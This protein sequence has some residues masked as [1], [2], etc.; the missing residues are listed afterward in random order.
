MHLYRDREAQAAVNNLL[1]V[2]RERDG[3]QYWTACHSERKLYLSIPN[4]HGT[5][6]LCLTFLHRHL[7]LNHIRFPSAS[8]HRE[9]NMNMGSFLPTKYHLF[10]VNCPYF[11]STANKLSSRLLCVFHAFLQNEKILDEHV[12]LHLFCHVPF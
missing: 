10:C 6:P 7:S 8:L 4:C 3:E 5:L 11:S 1:G 9:N 12:H 2:R